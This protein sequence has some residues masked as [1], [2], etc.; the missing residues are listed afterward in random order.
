MNG[1]LQIEMRGDSR[2]VIRIMIHI[3]AVGRLRRAP[4]T[5]AV[6]CDDAKAVIQEEHHLGVPIV[7]AQRPAVREDYRLSASPVLVEDVNAVF[8]LN[9]VHF[10]VSF[11]V[12]AMDRRFRG[13]LGRSDVTTF[14]V[15]RVLGMSGGSRFVSTDRYGWRM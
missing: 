9:R 11:V 5:A 8:G 13:G 4:V 1:V 12:V 15:A 6:M 14:L 7:R 3:V 2:E 10:L